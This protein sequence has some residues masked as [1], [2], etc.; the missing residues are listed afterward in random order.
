MG[1]LLTAAGMLASTSQQ[2][3]TR[4]CPKNP[5][6]PRS[7][8]PTP[9]LHVNLLRRGKGISA[10]AM[11]DAAAALSSFEDSNEA[12]G[13]N[14]GIAKRRDDDEQPTAGTTAPPASRDETS[15]RASK[16]KRPSKR[17]EVK[18]VLP[19]VSTTASADLSPSAI[20]SPA[21]SPPNVRPPR[22]SG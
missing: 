6:L 12:A 5:R 17:S 21:C 9:I 8:P 10:G 20:S 7:H 11:A 3:G 19:E 16:T 18:N 15:K 1:P 22:R 13:N 4:R 14:E 2:L